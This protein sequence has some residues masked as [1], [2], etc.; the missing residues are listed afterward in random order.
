MT[1]KPKHV[2]HIVYRTAGYNADQ[3]NTIT[4]DTREE[5][6]KEVDRYLT[7]LSNGTYKL[8]SAVVHYAQTNEAY[9]VKQVWERT[10]ITD[11]P[12]KAKAPGASV[13][14]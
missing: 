2:A 13:E 12:I 10:P 4:R 11:P 7:S 6:D 9:T 3:T 5:V 1:Y 8:Q 14:I